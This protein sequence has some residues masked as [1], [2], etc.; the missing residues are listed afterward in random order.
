MTDLPRPCRF[1]VSACLAGLHCRY[2]GRTNHKPE[3]AEL[4]ASGLAV[5]VCPEELGGLPTPRDPSDRRGDTVVSN[6]GRDVTFEFASGAEAALYI[7]EEYGCSAAILKARSPSCG[8]GMIYDGS[9]S[10]TLTDRDG[11]AAEMLKKNGISVFTEEEIKLL[12][13]KMA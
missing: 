6:A 2:D 12:L 10:G 8:S 3:V 7:A 4:V 11:V 13:E 5:P 1:V 9:F